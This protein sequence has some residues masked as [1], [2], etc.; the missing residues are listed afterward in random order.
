VKPTAKTGYDWTGD[1]LISGKLEDLEPG[2]MVVT[3][4]TGGSRKRP[5]KIAQLYVLLDDGN[6]IM[7]DEIKDNEWAYE[8]RKMARA[9]LALDQATR[10]RDAWQLKL[11][12]LSKKLVAAEAHRPAVHVAWAA[13]LEYLATMPPAEAGYVRFN[14]EGCSSSLWVAAEQD[15][16]ERQTKAADLFN[17]LLQKDAK[18]ILELGAA[19]EQIQTRL[20][21]MP[22][23]APETIS[24][25]DLHAER[26]T[27]L[28]RLAEIDS[29]LQAAGVLTSK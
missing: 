6:W 4:D 29:L 3:C 13:A 10:V 16:N 26:L 14:L 1:F 25:Q 7:V 8:L 11:E 21:V 12:R 15:S 20:T 28:A 19:I 22:E 24:V 23:P 27:L 17:E 2:T 9:W 5:V 18:S